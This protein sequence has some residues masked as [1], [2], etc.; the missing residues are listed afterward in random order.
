M[1]IIAQIAGPANQWLD[2]LFRDPTLSERVTYRKFTGRGA[3]S[4]QLGYPAGAYDDDPI[5]AVRLKHNKKSVA[6]VH[7]EVEVGDVLFV[8]RSPQLPSGIS[9]KDLI[10]DKSSVV[11]NV[12]D[13]TPVYGIATLITVKGG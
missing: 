1:S 4:K 9:K 5:T 13:I 2:E 10:V 3:F 6:V 11:F 7:G 8:F 12:N